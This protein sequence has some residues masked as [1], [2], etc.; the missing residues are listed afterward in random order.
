MATLTDLKK[1]DARRHQRMLLADVDLQIGGQ[2]SPSETGLYFAKIG[3]GDPSKDYYVQ[4]DTGS[5]ILWVNCAGCTKCPTKSDLGV[6]LTLYDPKSSTSSKLI[7][8]D[9]DFCTSTYEGQLPGCKPDL[10]CQY[11][12]VYGDGS[13]TAGYFVQDSLKLDQVTGNFQTGSLNG[14][15]VF[16]CGAKQSGELGSSSEALDGIL[17]FGQANSSMLSQ[18]SSAG[19]V[20]KMFAHCLDN[21]QGGGI[22]AIGEVV[23]PKINTTPMIPDMPHY[24]VVLKDIEVG[25]DVIDIPSSIFDTILSGKQKGAVI[26]SGT[27]LAYLPEAAYKP[28]MSKILSYQPNLKLHTVEE[29]FSCF[30]YNTDNID[31]GFPN[32][33]FNF[34][35][36]L[37]LVVYPHDYLFAIRDD[38]WCIGWQNSELQSKDGKDMILLGD[39]V[40]SN[41][42]VVYDVENQVIGWT[43]YNCSSSIKLKDG[44]SGTV[45]TVGAH[46]LSSASSP[47]NFEAGK[48]K[49]SLPKLHLNPYSWSKV[50]NIIY[51]DSP[52]GVGLSYSQNPKAYD[53]GDLQTAKDTHAFL[54]KWFE[55]YP[56]FVNNPFYISGE[57]YAGVYVPTLASAVVQGIKSGAKPT[58]NLKDVEAECK[59]KYYGDPSEKCYKSF[60]RVGTALDGLNVYDILE[61]C[62]HE[63]DDGNKKNK[64]NSL[65]PHTFQQ[66]G[67]NNSRP[68]AVRKRMFGR[69]WPFRAPVKGSGAPLAL[70]PEL[71]R[72]NPNH[73]PCVNDEVATVWLNDAS[74]RKSLH[75]QPEKLA[76]AWEICTERITYI[77]DAGSMIPYH[78]NLT[79]QG[80]R[81]LIYSGDHD[82][83]VP[84]TGSQAWTKSLG[85]KGAGHTVPEYKPREALDF[86]SRWLDGKLI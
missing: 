59:G 86:F 73:V 3:L 7:T 49:G 51:L 6:P 71:M 63:V 61:P 64:T 4:V 17:G 48:T 52:A 15:V 14:N 33:K 24:N 38:T 21:N 34:R 13:S 69:A 77:E 75:A 31:E 53:T 39:L 55:L 80:Y 45:Y 9:Q 74:V 58:I 60:E 68:L 28:L 42:L 66:L 8:C 67:K 83:C 81:A 85:Y 22:F 11:N 43:E 47:F 26:D 2:G 29:Q 84:F 76:G 36:S 20:K 82:M 25:G 50:S 78:I 56:E 12:V 79:S 37:S 23:S 18:L 5:D 30:V 44:K 65:L 16:G 19:K 1:H 72:S 70:W 46:N 57:S 40:L 27:T 62:Y 54:L 10:L 35:G 32:V 41:K